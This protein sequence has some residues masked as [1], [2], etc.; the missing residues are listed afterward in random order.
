[1][2]IYKEQNNIY[3][4]AKF[5]N[6]CWRS[7]Y[8]G[9][10]SAEY[11]DTLSDRERAKALQKLSDE[12]LIEF[13]GIRQKGILAGVCGYGK[14]ITEDFLNDGEI[15]SIYLSPECIGKGYGHALF[16]EAEKSLIN[17]GYTDFVVNTF[18]ANTRALLFYINH[19]YSIIKEKTI[20]FGDSDYPYKIL[21]K[22]HTGQ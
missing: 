3:E 21:R 18:T 1:M 13:L 12:G 2:I 19:G 10:L 16:S 7:S 20:R 5:L 8:A 14:S 9:I 22:C 17:K 11:L 6:A 15:Y 4:I